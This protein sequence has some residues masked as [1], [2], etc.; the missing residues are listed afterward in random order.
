MTEIE[1]GK[2]FVE[3]KEGA[4]GLMYSIIKAKNIEEAKKYSI[5]NNGITESEIKE[6]DISTFGC[7]HVG[8]E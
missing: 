7:V 1:S 6:V 2:I 5:Y 4:Y 3:E 8:G